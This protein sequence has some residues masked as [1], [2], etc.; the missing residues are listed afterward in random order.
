M[1]KGT[2]FEGGE[3]MTVWVTDDDNH[4]PVR[5]ESPISVGKVKIDMMSYENLRYPLAS[6]DGIYDANQTLSYF[7]QFKKI[8]SA[9]F[10]FQFVAGCSIHIQ[11][12]VQRK[13]Y[14]HFLLLL[15][16]KIFFHSM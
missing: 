8:V 10:L 4:I 7:F 9:V 15:S 11:D 14:N 13:E 16:K 1:I 3:K 6:S 2:I 12:H 5:I